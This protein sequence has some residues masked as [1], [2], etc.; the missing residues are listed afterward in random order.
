MLEIIAD[1]FKCMR[2]ILLLALCVVV[3]TASAGGIYSWTDESGNLVFGDSPPES[4]VAKPINPPKLTVLEN[5]STRYKTNAGVVNTRGTSTT[6]PAKSTSTD[7][8]KS[9]KLIAPKP[10]QVIRANDGDVSVALTLSPK[11]RAGDN[12][13]IKLDGVEKYRG[14]Q[15]VAN[16]S[17]LSRGSHQLEVSIVDRKN[18]VLKSSGAS[19]SVLRASALNKKPFNPY[20]NESNQ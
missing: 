20:L 6:A 16:L 11:L 3:Q 9:L 1:R 12:V 19:F 10:E 17:N 13:V 15:R 5:F 8:Y 4:V 18:T 14:T 7:Y 2:N